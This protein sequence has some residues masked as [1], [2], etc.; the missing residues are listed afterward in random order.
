LISSTLLDICSAQAVRGWFR[1]TQVSWFV[2][3]AKM[4]AATLINAHVQGSLP[5]RM[6]LSQQQHQHQHQ[7]VAA[8]D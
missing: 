4:D 1:A 7:Q 5:K 2:V 6:A 3:I 8:N